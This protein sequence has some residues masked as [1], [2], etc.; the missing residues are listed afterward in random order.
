MIPWPEGNIMSTIGMEVW[1][2][3]SIV[4]VLDLALFGSTTTSEVLVSTSFILLSS[5]ILNLS[6]DCHLARGVVLGRSS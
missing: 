2:L 4:E 6:S 5:I 1:A 3:A